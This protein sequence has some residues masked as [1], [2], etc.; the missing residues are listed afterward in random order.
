[1]VFK[2]F[3]F[4]LEPPVF[5]PGKPS[6][7]LSLWHQGLSGD[8]DNVWWLVFLFVF[9]FVCF[10]CFVLLFCFGF[11][12]CCFILFGLFCFVLFLFC[13]NCCYLLFCFVLL[14]FVCVLFLFFKFIFKFWL[15]IGSRFFF[16]INIFPSRSE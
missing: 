1:M 11:C 16:I 13:C 15:L 12:C 7:F 9:L 2:F 5:Q 3:I 8:Q 10:V 14:C 6:D 4:L